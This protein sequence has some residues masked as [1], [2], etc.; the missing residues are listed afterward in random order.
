M[1]NINIK[2]RT[3]NNVKRDNTKILVLVALS[4]IASLYTIFL[5]LTIK[6]PAVSGS[7]GVYAGPAALKDP[8]IRYLTAVSIYLAILGWMLTVYEIISTKK[9]RFNGIIRKII[10]NEG[11][12][13]D[14]Y[15]IFSGRGGQRRLAIMQSLETPK[16]RNEIARI[17]NIDWKEVDRNVRILQAENLVKMDFSHGSLKVYCLTETGKDLAKIIVSYESGTSRNMAL[18]KT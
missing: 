14:I 5:F 4:A 12:D 13:R 6:N 7:F 10:N 3:E 9:L 8:I 18:V 15:R 1:G 11:F 16:L 17:T 2:G